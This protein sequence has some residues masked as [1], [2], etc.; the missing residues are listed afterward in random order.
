M[1]PTIEGSV[2]SINNTDSTKK[3]NEITKEN[4]LPQYRESFTSEVGCH[5][6][7]SSG[8]GCH[9]LKISKLKRGIGR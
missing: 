4:L 2:L 8:V 1:T 5:P 6:L 7:I 3:I 9:L